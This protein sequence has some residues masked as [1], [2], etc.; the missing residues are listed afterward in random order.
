MLIEL[1]DE[2]I[3]LICESI[4]KVRHD[5]HTNEIRNIIVEDGRRRP[6][7]SP[8]VAE[9]HQDPEFLDYQTSSYNCLSYHYRYE[10]RA[11]LLALCLTSK[12]VANEAQRILYRDVSLF[13]GWSLRGWWCPVHGKDQPLATGLP[14]AF[15]RDKR[16]HQ[17]FP[18]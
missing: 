8:W 7:L 6:S 3:G 16:K 18:L 10:Y 4:V 1:P 5:E 11:D 9:H 2:L 13:E 14:C 15:A 17:L 12:K